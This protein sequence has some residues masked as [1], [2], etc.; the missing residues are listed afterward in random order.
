MGGSFLA[1]DNS[2]TYDTGDRLLT[3]R[4]TDEQEWVAS[5]PQPTSWFSY[6]DLGNRISHRY[7]TGSAI[8]YAHDKANRMTTLANR[9]QGYDPA[10][11]LTLAYSVDRGTSYVYRYDHH[12]RLTGVYD[13]TNTTRK[14]AFT[15]DALGRRIEHVNDVLAGTTRYYY[16]GVNE[17]VED[18]GSGTRRRYYVHGVS[19]IDE[20]LMMYR[21]SDSRPY[22]YVVDRMYNVRMLIDRAGAVVE[23]YA[24]DS[25][26]RPRIRES[27][28]RGDMD[29]DTLMGSSDTTRFTNA[30]NGSIWD[31]RADLDDDGDVD[32]ADQTLYDAKQPNWTGEGFDGPTVAQAFSDVDNPYMF[33]GV[34]HFALDTAADATEDKLSL[35]HHRAR[36]AD[37][38][39]GRWITR[40]PLHLG[41]KGFIHQLGGDRIANEHFDSLLSMHRLSRIIDASNLFDMLRNRPII[42]VDPSGLLACTWRPCS[43]RGCRSKT[44]YAYRC[45][46]PPAM[47]NCDAYWPEMHAEVDAELATCSATCT[48]SC[49]CTLSDGSLVTSLCQFSSNYRELANL[50]VDGGCEVNIDHVT[51]VGHLCYLQAEIKNKCTCPCE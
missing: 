20:R 32:S 41:P 5:F 23:R 34:T 29:D 43:L 2:H 16:D 10:G 33:Q 13:S 3:T 18:N 11:N 46:T 40:D 28:G 15:W 44:A 26:G 42:T 30:K 1:V 8:G 6:D 50:S 51:T 39:T 37:C 47:L 35:N 4:Y 25:Y 45:I 17:I 27:A 48:W 36:F 22:Y 14:A 31:P 24:Y 12:N 49:D 21:D 19:Y 7:R 38:P 9:T